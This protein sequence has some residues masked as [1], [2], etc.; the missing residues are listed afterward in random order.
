VA[1][2]AVAGT[3]VILV[4]AL[5]VVANELDIALVAQLL[6]PSNEPVIPPSTANPPDTINPSPNS[7]SPTT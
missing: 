5:A 7:A 1:N 6:V 3:N 2:D 4:A